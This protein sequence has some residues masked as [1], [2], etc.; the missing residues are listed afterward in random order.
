MALTAGTAQA[1]YEEAEGRTRKTGRPARVR[2][3]MYLVIHLGSVW[4][5]QK[6][7]Y[8]DGIKS[9]VWV[10]NSAECRGAYTDACRT[11]KDLLKVCTPDAIAPHQVIK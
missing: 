8:C 5:L 6:R 3:G 9:S 10:G 4:Q 1:M 7:D 2:P 11:L